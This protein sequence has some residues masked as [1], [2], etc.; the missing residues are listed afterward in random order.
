[1]P[2]QPTYDTTLRRFLLFADK[3]IKPNFLDR[4]NRING[5]SIDKTIQNCATIIDSNFFIEDK[6]HNIKLH[7]RYLRMANALNDKLKTAKHKA[8]SIMQNDP[9]E[10]ISLKINLDKTNAHKS[11]H[12][13]GIIFLDVNSDHAAYVIELLINEFIDKQLAAEIKMSNE[14]SAAAIITIYFKS[15]DSK[16]V[17]DIVEECND[18]AKLVF[19]QK[20]PK[21]S[22][23]IKTSQGT[24]M[25]GVAFGELPA[26]RSLSFSALRSLVLSKAYYKYVTAIYFNK[27]I[28]QDSD[29][30]FNAF[31]DFFKREC[32]NHEISTLNPAFNQSDVSD[33]AKIMHRI[34]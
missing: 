22:S 28:S 26:N 11:E 32:A 3:S 2:E 27:D 29:I 9:N 10:I 21:F 12:Y 24:V 5:Q 1:M 34:V 15:T 7:N 31:K 33:F 20:I 30:S 14:I 16:A 23:H 13:S 18:H 4:N 17:L 8:I 19:R 6:N 25:T